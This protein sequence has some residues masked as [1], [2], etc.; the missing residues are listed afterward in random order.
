L[1]CSG[2]GFAVLVCGDRIE[3]RDQ[4]G[5]VVPV[6]GGQSDGE[7]GAAAIDERMVLGA[8]TASVIG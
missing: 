1:V 7:R 3:K 4:L 6:P 8:D 2:V 5:D